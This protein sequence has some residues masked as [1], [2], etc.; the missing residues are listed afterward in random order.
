MIRRLFQWLKPYKWQYCWGISLGV[1]MILMQ[2][3]GPWFIAYLVDYTTKF[4]NGRLPA[5]VTRIA[6]IRWAGVVVIAWAVLSI[7]SLLLDRARILIMTTA[8]ESVQFDMRRGNLRAPAEAQHELLRPHEARPN[9]QPSDQRRE[10]P[11]RSERVGYRCN[12]AEWADDFVA[13]GGHW[14]H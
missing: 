9:H 5:S 2:M 14:Q 3:T 13:A 10:Q 11:A 1:V 7:A 4:V 8:G 12:A 6:A